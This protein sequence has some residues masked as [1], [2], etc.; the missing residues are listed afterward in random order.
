M[1]VD[2]AR[3][4]QAVAMILVDSKIETGEISIAVI[5]DA[6]MHKLNRQHLQ[7]DY[8]TDVLSFVLERSDTL[9][10]GEIIVSSDTALARAAEFQLHPDDE[11]LLYVIH[12]MLHLVGYD[13]KNESKRQLMRNR[14][15]HYLAQF[16]V[17]HVQ[18]AR[19]SFDDYTAKK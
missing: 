6:T 1:Q 11:L 14:E 12:G 15:A 17:R 4:R 7:H 19:P 5:D 8:P 13:D 2:H 3:I 10:E 18:D 16:G 9:L